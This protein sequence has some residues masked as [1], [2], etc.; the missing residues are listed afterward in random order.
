MLCVT[1]CY[2]LTDEVSFDVCCIQ[3]TDDDDNATV[4][5][6]S[7]KRDLAEKRLKHVHKANDASEDDLPLMYPS[8]PDQVPCVLFA[9]QLCSSVIEMIKGSSSCHH[10]WP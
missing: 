9:R 8:D 5:M 3:S 2:I 6:A 10:R 4:K 7:M 1:Q